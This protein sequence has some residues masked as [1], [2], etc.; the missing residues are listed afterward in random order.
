MTAREMFEKLGF[1]LEDECVIDG[2]VHGLKYRYYYDYISFNYGE[3]IGAYWVAYFCDG[4]EEEPL[5]IDVEQTKACIQ[6]MKE[7]GWLD[8][9]K[10]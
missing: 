7:L 4:G 3:K 2:V 6:Q 8:V 10:D 1:E 9:E 5:C